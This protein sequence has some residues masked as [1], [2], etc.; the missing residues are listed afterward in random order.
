MGRRRPG[1][2]RLGLRLPAPADGPRRHLPDG[3]RHARRRGRGLLPARPEPGRR[4]RQ[5]PPAADGHV[6]PEVAGGARPQHD[7]VGHLVEGRPGDRLRRAAHRRHR[8]RGVLHARRE[9]RGEGRVVHPDPADAAV[10]S[11]GHRPAGRLPE[12]A[13]LLL[14]A[15]PADQGQAGRL[16]RRTRPAA[17][18]SDL[19]LSD[20]RTTA[21]PTPRRCWRRST[22]TAGPARTPAS[23]SRRTPSCGPT[24]RRPP[25]A[26]STPG[27][28][29]TAS[30]TRPTGCR[31]AVRG[32]PSRSGAG[33]GR[34]TGGSSTTGPRP[35]PTASRGA[36]G[37]SGSGGT[38]SRRRWVGDDVPDFVAD[39]APGSRPDPDLGGPAAL[40][41][42]DAVHHAVRRQGLAVRPQGHGRRAAARALRA[43]GVPG[44]QRGLPAAAE[45]LPDH[46]P[47]DGQPQRAER[48]ARPDRT[49][50][51]TCSPPTG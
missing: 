21:T 18:G 44:R 16:D 19:G 13:G 14:P 3:D 43:A 12:R 46:V 10:A 47:A 49:C 28:T 45:P 22:A 5:R 6:P 42:D 4:V 34:P 1:R 2:Q 41:G 17:A 36:N 35:P 25:A 11:Q 20:R 37:R 30:T 32:G 33:P 48:R 38:R 50:T 23:R 24:G 9:P 51:R 39:R 8:D 26:G 27:C 31:A 7:R 40:A 29:P 15:R